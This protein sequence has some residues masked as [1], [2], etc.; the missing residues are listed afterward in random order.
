MWFLDAP[1]GAMNKDKAKRRRASCKMLPDYS[2]FCG[3]PL[4]N[5]FG[6]QFTE[7]LRKGHAREKDSLNRV[8]QL[9]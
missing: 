5:R 6:K 3:Y 8:I 4:L 9:E 7:S 1:A 2:W